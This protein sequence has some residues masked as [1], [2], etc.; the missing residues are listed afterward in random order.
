MSIWIC[1]IYLKHYKMWLYRDGKKEVINVA[2]LPIDDLSKGNL[3]SGVQVKPLGE[4]LPAEKWVENDKAQQE[5]QE[6]RKLEE[7]E[8]QEQEQQEEVEQE[9]HQNEESQQEEKKPHHDIPER[10]EVP[11]IKNT[12][13]KRQLEEIKNMLLQL[14]DE[15]LGSVEDRLK[16]I[17]TVV[18]QQEEEAA[19]KNTKGKKK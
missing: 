18:Q 17:E 19:Q 15:K 5:E 1:E 7:E 16:N 6:R 8:K 14:S 11:D 3:M 9:E 13:I 10:E 4:S 2:A 12:Y